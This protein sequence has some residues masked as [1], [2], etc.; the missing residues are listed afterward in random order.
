MP[1]P[2]HSLFVL[3][4]SAVAA[5]FVAEGCVGSEPQVGS[6]TDAGTQG[7]SSLADAVSEATGSDAA[8][9]GSDGSALD[10]GSDAPRTCDLGLDNWGTPTLVGGVNGNSSEED[11]SLTD[12]E[13]IIFFASDRTPSAGLSFDIWTASRSDRTLPF[14]APSIVDVET[15]NGINTSQDERG[16]SVTG[17]GLQLFF[18]SSRTGYDLWQTSRASLQ[19]TF[20]APTAIG[21]LN[22]AGIDTTPFA[23]SDGSELFYNSDFAPDAG[24][25]MFEAVPSGGAWTSQRLSGAAF[26]AG[27]NSAMATRDGLRIFFAS[28]RTPTSG[29][30][31]IWTAVRTAKNQPFGVA[32][33]VTTLNSASL[34]R[35]SWISHDG[36]R[37]YFWSGRGGAFHIYVAE[38]TP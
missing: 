32:T 3:L 24:V 17:N 13:L 9:A 10:S 36:C 1:R 16:A 21:S 6:G 4:A 15:A 20:A 18:H 12:D 30:E 27:D 34:D 35:P 2:R 28:P 5:A 37:F 7:D 33:N 29:G 31:D 14:N 19:A 22:T 38:R 23:L 26:V 25:G 11:P 8:D